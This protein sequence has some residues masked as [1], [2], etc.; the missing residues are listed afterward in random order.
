VIPILD[1]QNNRAPFPGN[2][3]P[4]TRIDKAGQG[5]LNVFPLPNTVDSGN[6][7]N[8]VF[9]GRVSEPHHFEVLRVDWNISPKTTFYTRLHHNGDKR[10][11]SDWF[12]GFPVN[13]TFPSI[14]GSYEFPSRGGWEP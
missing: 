13:N 7:F 4:P 1:P 8:T 12:N 11:S 3:I 10:K 5:L 6:T 14:A 2:V 9:Q